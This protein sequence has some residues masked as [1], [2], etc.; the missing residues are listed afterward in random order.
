MR[1]LGL[2]ILLVEDDLDNLELLASFLEGEGAQ[3]FGAGSIAAALALTAD[4]PIDAVVSDLELADGDGC[5]LLAEL[6]NRD[7]R[8]ELPAIAVT[9][10]SEQ[11]WRNKAAGC[12]FHRYAV[13][14]YSLE[15]LV[16]WLAELTA[17]PSASSAEICHDEPHRAARDR[18]A[19]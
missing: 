9:G 7:G 19:R 2:K 10:Y 17:P 16:E 15:S 5:G 4:H 12:G 13:K 18:L 1:L 14:P 6:K 11:K 8:T 3:T